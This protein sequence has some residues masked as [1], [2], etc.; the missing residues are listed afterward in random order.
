MGNLI[1]TVFAK[2]VEEEVTRA[3]MIEENNLQVVLVIDLV[4][5]GRLGE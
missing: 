2:Y 3:Q 4:A 1:R 5:W